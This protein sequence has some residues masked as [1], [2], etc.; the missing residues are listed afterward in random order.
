MTK[1]IIGIMGAMPQ[2]ISGVIEL[3]DNPVSTTIGS[4]TY[5]TG[6]INS[7]DTVVVFSRWGKV[8]ATA[9]VSALIH[10]FNITEL[11][12]TG[13]AGAIN[14]QLNIGD[15]VIGQKL[16]QH[17]MDARPLM[18]QFEIPLLS[19]TYIETNPDQLTIAQ[20][21]IER[22]LQNDTISNAVGREVLNSFNIIAPKFYTGEIA[23]G[24]RFFANNDQKDNLLAALP[25]VL[26]VEMEGAAVA[27]VCYEYDIPFT[28]IRTISDSANDTSHID[29]P[30]FIKKVSSQY[31]VVIIQAIYNIYTDTQD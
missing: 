30:V 14:H 13:V 18:K 29:F 9:T 11:I 2:E 10:H 24:D 4:R 16:I 5:T 1:P 28:V 21:A 6:T 12:F 26:C 25:D 23:S 19:K 27:Q 22:L 31:S 20:K 3:L 8:S 15:I 7:I 17:D